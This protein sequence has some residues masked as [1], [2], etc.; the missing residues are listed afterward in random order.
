M[1]QEGEKGGETLGCFKEDWGVIT[2]K[3]HSL[4]SERADTFPTVYFELAVVLKTTAFFCSSKS[5]VF[6]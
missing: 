1:I 2:V 6:Y 3:L 5:V 4:Y